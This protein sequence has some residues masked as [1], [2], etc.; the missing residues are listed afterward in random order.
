MNDKAAD[1]N[2]QSSLFQKLAARAG[3]ITIFG[4]TLA[5]CSQ[6]FG[7]I[8][9]PP[10]IPVVSYKLEKFSEKK[11]EYN[12]IFIG[13]SRIYRHIVPSKFDNLMKSRGHN[14]KSYNFGV[15][16]MR[17]LETYFLLKQIM[18]MKPKNLEF[19]FIELYDVNLSVASDN[20][21]TNRVKY[22]HTWEHTLWIY[23]LILD[24]DSDFLRKLNL[25]GLHTIPLS[26]NLANVGKGDRLIQSIL[27]PVDE[28]NTTLDI[29]RNRVFKNPGLEGYLSLDEETDVFFKNRR[30]D[31]LANLDTYRQKVES[32]QV[33]VDKVETIKPYQLAVIKE[34]MQL[35]KDSG[36]T[37]IFILTPVLEKEPHL[38]A[39]NTKGYLPILFSFNDPIKYPSLYAAEYRFDTA[40]LTDR[41]AKEFTKLLS[42]KFSEY[43]EPEKN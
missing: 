15:Y 41:G 11:D 13:S 18:A 42:E 1:S 27:N 6:I 4:A 24:S 33:P 14:I 7:R 23:D 28:E 29:G 17:A 9:P 25:L 36:A 37:P 35:V 21:R 16:A 31:F 32:I 34:L 12:T 10:E 3:I 2:K 5:L 43:L 26:Y 40:H 38:L 22:W 20:L 30:Q 39:A 8:T 19:V